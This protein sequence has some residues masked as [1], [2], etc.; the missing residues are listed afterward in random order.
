VPVERGTEPIALVTTE[1][2]LE[3]WTRPHDR[4]LTELLN[5]GAPLP[6]E[7]KGERGEPEWQ[8]FAPQ[9]LVAVVPMPLPPS[10]RHVGESRPSAVIIRTH[11][12]EIRGVAH[13]PSG[14]DEERYL[15]D[16]AKPWL[17]LTE[18]TIREGGDE[19]T[20]KV[21]IANLDQATELLRA[22]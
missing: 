9:R 16:P 7:L 4:R 8:D 19:W 22:S 20:A 17:P 11:R 12:F 2:V 1:E 6:V 5:A 10:R 15:L 14:A 13:V 21:V 18:A 3:G